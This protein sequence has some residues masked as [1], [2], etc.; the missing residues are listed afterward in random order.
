[1]RGQKQPL[2]P[3][4][5][6][7]VR[8]CLQ[9]GE[10]TGFEKASTDGVRWMKWQYFSELN[11]FLLDPAQ[12]KAARPMAGVL[13]VSAD[14][15]HR[16]RYAAALERKGFRTF[17]A[18]TV[19]KA[20]DTCLLYRPEALLSD[21]VT[22]GAGGFELL[23]VLRA[24][25]QTALIPVVLVSAIE[26]RGVWSK[27]FRHGAADIVP[28]S[29]DP[30]AV[31]ARI[32]SII[33]GLP[34]RS[35]GESGKLTQ[36]VAAELIKSIGRIRLS[37]VLHVTS[38]AMDGQV[39]FD[40]GEVIEARVGSLLHDEAIGAI[41]KFETG[42]YSFEEFSG[43]SGLVGAASRGDSRIAETASFREDRPL[44]W[45]EDNPGQPFI[46]RPGDGLPDFLVQPV[47]FD[48][49]LPETAANLKPCAVAI[50]SLDVRGSEMKKTFKNDRRL[51][52][53][54]LILV[55]PILSAGAPEGDERGLGLSLAAQKVFANT[56]RK[57]LS[58]TWTLRRM[59]AKGI[60]SYHGTLREIG[61]ATLLETLSDRAFTGTLSLEGPFGASSV[62]LERG[63][64]VSA[65]CRGALRAQGREAFISLMYWRA[66]RFSISARSAAGTPN[67][68]GGMTGMLDEAFSEVNSKIAGA[69]IRLHAAMP[70]KLSRQL[71]DADLETL[72]SN[73]KLVVAL[74]DE[75]MQPSELV[76][77]S[78]LAEAETTEILT[79][80]IAMGVVI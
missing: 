11:A 19:E 15:D 54:P 56:M 45:A 42:E 22:A 63:A 20:Y 68:A 52:E 31:A 58:P 28:A 43:V 69:Q 39:V 47:A 27:G 7:D 36:G 9:T 64:P 78:G 1:V 59:T 8:T 6:A 16:A 62:A 75:Q 29:L 65:T 73:V 23:K 26:G 14:A 10:L 60:E 3:L 51:S 12:R 13:I 80:L 70:L 46:W 4:D 66:G 55:S 76:S 5:I 30:D 61:P 53:I 32:Q 57:T 33:D 21:V 40:Q 17:S 38:A 71:D 44:I 35:S 18:E 72:S 41:A 34:F 24:D 49:R 48:D 37:G 50:K 79:S 77:M 2:G 67:L 25:P 74:A